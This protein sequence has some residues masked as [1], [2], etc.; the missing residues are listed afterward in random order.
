MEIIKSEDLSFT[1]PGQEKK[2]V[3]AVSFKILPGEFVVICGESGCG[4]TTLLKL[5][6]RE[7]SPNGNLEG[8]IYY[9]GTRLG[10]LDERTAA[11]DIG[12]VMQNPE[13][14]VV[15]DKVWHELAFG[16]ENM[17]VPTPEIRRRVGEMASFFGIH[18]W[19]QKETSQLSG[20]QKQL[21]N[22]ASIM[23]MQPK[24]LILDEPTSQLDPIAAADFINTLHKLNRELGLTILLVEHRLEEVFP[25]ADKV[26]V[27]DRGH[28]LLYD[29]PRVIGS[30][31]KAKY[32]NHPMLLGLPSPMRIYQQL[33][34]RDDC[35]LTIREGR[36]F[37][38][39]NYKEESD[40]HPP[41]YEKT[42][43]K[44]VKEEELAVHLK[45][46]WFRYERALPDILAGVDLK[47]RKGEIFSIL[48]GNGSGKTT[49]LSVISGQ[50]KP[51]RGGIK[52]FGKKIKEYKS[53]E[54]YRHNLALLPQNPQTVFLKT[55]VAEDY[56]EIGKVMGY[57]KEELEED[58]ARIAGQ[59][60]IQDLLHKHP[61]D[62]SGG[63]QQK[64]AL[65][66]MLLLKPKCLLL[67]EPTKGIDAYSK[68]VLRDILDNL[69]KEG[70]TILLVTHDVE[71]AAQI[72]DRCSLFFDREVIS[73]DTPVSFFSNN[74]FYTTAA[75][76]MARHMYPYAI[77][78]EDVVA[79][80]R[81]YGRRS[82]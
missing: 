56:K 17:G 3:D 74:N 43:G 48:G 25:I 20:G 18:E 73:E 52:I 38:S 82:I 47:V 26:A 30:E 12:Y 72:S 6:K 79:L 19:F 70:I 78:C 8:E 31:L 77:T 61:Y 55:S 11:C 36:D 76:R 1:Y 34:A 50:N 65:G 71:F 37:L 60:N 62:L 2:A 63:E 68:A 24:I 81:K 9:M 29:T 41:E 33:D 32:Q 44:R 42:A 35:P 80:C 49:L 5:L 7:L 66:K 40:I 53:G 23:V 69:R 54:L 4:K 16:L 39:R 15:T 46:I 13:N 28:L 27:M 51:Y 75:N 59:L 10:E 58:I 14:Q 67:D 45:N 57:G 64:A 22:L 21:L